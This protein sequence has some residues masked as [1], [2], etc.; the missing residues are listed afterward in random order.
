MRVMAKG[1][2]ALPPALVGEPWLIKNN[3]GS[4]SLFTLEND[5]F[6]IGRYLVQCTSACIIWIPLPLSPTC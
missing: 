3:Y 1:R 2:W 6:R 4:Y 5:W